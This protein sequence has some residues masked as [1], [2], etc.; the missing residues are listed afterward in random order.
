MK[1]I[2]NVVRKG[3]VQD[4]HA[5]VQQMKEAHVSKTAVSPV[6]ECANCRDREY[7]IDGF[8]AVECHC[9]ARKRKQRMVKKMEEI[10]A[11]M[12]TGEFEDA[13]FD[14]F[15]RKDATQLLMWEKAREYVDQFESIRGSRLHS[16]GMVAQAG[17]LEIMQKPWKE[18]S[19]LL[20][21]YNSYG[22]G[23]THLAMAMADELIKRGYSVMIV[24]DVPFLDNLAQA[25]VHDNATY[26]AM[27]K[28]VIE[29]DVLVWDEFGK[30]KTSDFTNRV[31]YQIIDERYR[32]RRPIIY[33]SNE[34]IDTLDMMLLPATMSRLIGM[35]KELLELRGQDY[36]MR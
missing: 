8:V 33:T 11:S 14:N 2:N 10:R 24:N 26:L 17:E 32:M 29:M 31:I 13:T 1:T 30:G 18:R 19:K 27:M 36:R 9:K 22:I 20:K 25:R 23:K 28:H 4:I 34:S 6:Y 16:F 35:T 3:M 21:N 12:I 5:R 15:E 7:L